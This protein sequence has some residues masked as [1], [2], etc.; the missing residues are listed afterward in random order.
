M[1]SALA[2]EKALTVNQSTC[3]GVPQVPLTTTY[4]KIVVG[5]LDYPLK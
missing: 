1:A 4:P 5:A 3:K 2:L